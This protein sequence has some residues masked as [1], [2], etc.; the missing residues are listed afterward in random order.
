MSKNL[1]H[2]LFGKKFDKKPIEKKKNKPIEPTESLSVQTKDFYR[3][4]ND[5]ST[6]ALA[7]NVLNNCI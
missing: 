3:K 5:N 4:M 1:I 7:M 6:K 2:S